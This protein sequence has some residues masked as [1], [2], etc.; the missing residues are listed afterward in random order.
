MAG[1]L[2]HP[3]AKI[4]RQLLVNLG[5]GTEPSSSGAWPIYYASMPSSPDSL[6]AVFDDPVNEFMD[7]WHQ[8]DGERFEAPG[9]QIAIRGAR[10]QGAWDK[11]EAL[12]VAI[13]GS[14]SYNRTV[15]IDSSR[16]V[17]QSITRR[18]GPRPTKAPDSDRRV[19]FVNAAAE[20]NKV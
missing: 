8:Y 5:I 12:R 19:I 3:P 18:G 2:N 20:I 16:Y 15:S 1:V 7:G 9:I 14:A 10:D 13:D 4:I 6:I 17:V 11:W